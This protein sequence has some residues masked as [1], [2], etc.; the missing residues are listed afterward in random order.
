MKINSG[1]S[2]WLAFLPNIV[3]NPT[4]DLPTRLEIMHNGF[5]IENVEEFRYLGF[6]TTY[7]L[8]H[9]K[10]VKAR[11]A[12][13]S[14]AARFTG[15]LLRSLEITNFRSLRAYFYS[16]VGSQLYSLSVISFP[17]VEYD[18]SAKQFVQECFSLPSSFPMIVAKLFLRIDDLIMQAFNAR[19]NFFNRVLTG[20]N[21]DASLSAMHMDRSSLFPDERGWNAE[22]ENLVRPFVDFPSIDLSSVAFVEDTRSTLRSALS[23]RRRVRFEQSSS[24]F[25]TQLLPDL[26]IPDPFTRFLSE[27]PHESVRLI[28]IFFANM[29]QFTYLRTTSL[30]CAFCQLNL[31]STHLFDCLGITPNPISNWPAFV[32]DF[33]SEEYSRAFDRLFLILQRWTILTNRFQPSLSA[34]IQEY[35]E[36]TNFASRRSNF[37][38]LDSFSLRS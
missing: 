13:M 7:D 5:R 16:L 2:K 33:L 15:R 37:P 10:H 12:L 27:L 38:G 31:S 1:K 28:L 6:L 14:L 20:V 21:S 17:E 8:S 34:H 35:F 30:V 3:R 23:R 19:V 22:F 18:R 29:F 32:H 4:F 24:S 36:D 11:V 26:N 9:T 25:V